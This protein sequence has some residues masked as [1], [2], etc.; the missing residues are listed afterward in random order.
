MLLVGGREDPQAALQGERKGP[1]TGSVLPVLHIT[2][3]HAVS[4]SGAKSCILNYP[5]KV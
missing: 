3:A 4:T 1:G 2:A 5:Q